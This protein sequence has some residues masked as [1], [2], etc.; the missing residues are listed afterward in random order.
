MILPIN[1]YSS[2]NFTA[3]KF[4]IPIKG[5]TFSIDGFPV[6]TEKFEGYREYP[7]PNAEKL[8]NEAINTKNLAEKIRLFSEMGDYHIVNINTEKLVDKVLRRSLT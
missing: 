2:Q 1:G 8:Y 4:R 5:I 3:N 7:N 6:H